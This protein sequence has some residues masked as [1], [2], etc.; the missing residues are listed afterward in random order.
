MRA[1]SEDEMAETEIAKQAGGGPVEPP[2]EAPNSRERLDAMLEDMLD[3]P[4]HR[5]EIEEEIEGTFTQRKTVMCLDMSGFSRTTKDRGIVAFLLMIHQ[6]QLLAVPVV[7]R[8]NGVVIK[9]EAD[10]LFCLF[11]EVLD[12]VKA[13]REI[14]TSLKTANVVLPK[15]MELYV[16]IGIGYGPILNIENEDVWG[17]EVN[18]SSK[19]GEDIAELGEILL[20]TEARAQ[21]DDPSLNFIERNIS[22]SG[23]DVTFYQVSM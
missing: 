8:H 5:D 3:R 10:N 6:M 12:A 18:L 20:T 1:T 13:S 23:L 4:E 7:E 14:A 17:N 2:P 11:D 21:V 19:L 22:I 9:K 16:S 15:D